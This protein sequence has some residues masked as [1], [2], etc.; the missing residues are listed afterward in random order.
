MPVSKNGVRIKR[1]RP[2]ANDHG[3]QRPLNIITDA[4]WPRGREQSV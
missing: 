4:W 2:V 3:G 1:W